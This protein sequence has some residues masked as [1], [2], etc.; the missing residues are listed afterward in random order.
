METTSGSSAGSFQF[1]IKG[2][3]IY[4]NIAPTLRVVF[5]FLIKGYRNG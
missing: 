4:I 5:Q 2:Y 3:R 1:L